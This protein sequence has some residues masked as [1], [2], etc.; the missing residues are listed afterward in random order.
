MTSANHH[1]MKGMLASTAALASWLSRSVARRVAA[2]AAAIAA[3]V[4]AV[5]GLGVV[6]LVL[7]DEP[8][9]ERRR[10][11]LVALVGGVGT[12][13]AVAAGTWAIVERLLARRLR[14]LTEVV[15]AA[16]RGRYLTKVKSQRDDEL[17]ILSRAFDHL[18]SQIT[19]LSVAQIE[20]GRELEWTRRELR[21]KETVAL[22][23]ELTQS[24][25]AETDVDAILRAMCERVAPGLSVAEMA[26]LLYDERAQQLTVRATAG[27]TPETDPRGMRF[28][29]DEGAVGL[30]ATS[31]QSLYIRDTKT[32]PRY[33]HFKGKHVHE[34]SFMCVPMKLPGRLVGVLMALR[35]GVDMFGETDRRLLESLASTAGLAIAHAEMTAR[36]AEL[37]VTDEL[38]QVAN[39]RFLL[40]RLVREVDRAR[41]GTRPLAVL[42]LDLD[43]FK[44][45]NDEYGHQRGDEVLRGVARELRAQLRRIDTVGR[46]GGEE[47][48]VL[49]PDTARAQALHVAE[50]LRES[51][52]HAA[53]PDGLTMTISI[54]VAGLPEDASEP[55]ALIEAADRALFAAKRAGRDRVTVYQPGQA[56]REAG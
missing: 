53:F 38:T 9:D 17:G 21:L 23:F 3:A 22:I 34:G 40:E 43:H 29:A 1:R 13:L 49:L 14:E 51:V 2:L 45:V 19:D 54:G 12:V 11:M 6:G 36:L 44:R 42:M 16:E 56:A 31:G 26:L 33:L 10:L 37:A 8:A 18:V 46:Y 24:L 47:F 20:S 35:E 48:V 15:Q 28:G 30:V 52:K 50:K 27:F 41:R 25:S 55:D 5:V 7:G 32:D 39:R 4:A